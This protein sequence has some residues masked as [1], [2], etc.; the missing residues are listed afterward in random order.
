M[1]AGF[2]R[3]DIRQD[4]EGSASFLT[5]KQKRAEIIPRQLSQH[6]SSPFPSTARCQLPLFVHHSS[7]GHPPSKALNLASISCICSIRVGAILPPSSSL[8]HF[9]SSEALPRPRGEKRKRESTEEEGRRREEG[10]GCESCEGEGKGVS[11]VEKRQVS[12][13]QGARR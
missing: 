10:D 6:V 9:V 12:D 11:E 7:L 13:A 8:R 3:W 2:R 1:I 4:N 5:V